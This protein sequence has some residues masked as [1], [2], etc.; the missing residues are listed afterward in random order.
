MFVYSVVNTN[1][2]G[3]YGTFAHED[4]ATA[5]SR[6]MMYRS[7]H[8]SGYPEIEVHLADWRTRERVRLNDAYYKFPCW[9]RERWW[10]ESDVANNHFAHISREDPSQIAYTPD[11]AYG[12]K[13]RKIRCKPG[14]YLNK[15]FGPG[16]DNPVL[17]AKQIAYYA[18]WW[19]RGSPPPSARLATLQVQF[20]KTPRDIGWVYVNGPH[21]CMDGR[22]FDDPDEHPCRVYGAG[23][24]AIAYLEYPAGMERQGD[25][26][27]N[28]VIARALCWPEK[29]IVGRIYPNTDRS[30]EDG[31][32]T[33]QDAEGVAAYLLNSL[34]EQGYQ[35]TYEVGIS[36]LYGARLLKIQGDD[37]Y[38]MPY[39]DQNMM[40]QDEGDVFIT[41]GNGLSCDNTSGYLE[42]DRPTCHNCEDRYD[43]D[44]STTVYTRY[45]PIYGLSGHQYW[46]PDCADSDSFRCEGYGEN[47][48]AGQF[49]ET[50]VG[51]LTYSLRWL[52]DNGY[53]CAKTGEWYIIDDNPPTDVGGEV[54][55]PD[56]V[57]QHAFLCSYDERWYPVE[58]QS[59]AFP[60][61]HKQ[62]D[63]DVDVH[64]ELADREAAA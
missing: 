54:W 9:Q 24:L 31:F 58:D 2:G 44:D 13:D 53:V 38:V 3:V 64:P 56:A 21:S 42:D 11:A 55:G 12:E 5:K 41:A 15:F 50:T 59:E 29:K 19:T 37:G 49:D 61:F 48:D 62:Y 33:P 30:H 39:L 35:S 1:G 17:S 63:N 45:S 46:C 27:S 60:G 51:G 28:K 6:A 36:K 20:A 26:G 40:V 10:L 34:R 43:A 18:E 7:N 16:S 8:Y 32:K 4:E 23:D 22:E 57:G 25:L 52:E 14:R 47:M